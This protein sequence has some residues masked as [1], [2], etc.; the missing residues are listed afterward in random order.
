MI[1]GVVFLGMVALMAWGGGGATVTGLLF[2]VV[3]AAAISLILG[4][5]YRREH[6]P[7]CTAIIVLIAAYF[8]RAW[9]ALERG[10]SFPITA[11]GDAVAWA[12]LAIIVFMAIAVTVAHVVAPRLEFPAA[13]TEYIA[14]AGRPGVGAVGIGLLVLV[15]T[16]AGFRTGMWSHYGDVVKVEAGGVRMELLYFPLLFGFSAAIG[17]MAL[18]ELIG[19]KI[20]LQRAVPIGLMWTLTIVLLFIAQSRRAMLGALILTLVSAWLETSRISLIRTVVVTAGLGVLTIALVVG[21]YL[22]RHAGPATDAVEQLKVISDSSVNIE[23]LSQNLSDRLTYLWIDSASIE[24]YQV[25]QSQFDLLD[26]ANTSVIRATPEL[27][28]PDKYATPKIVCEH[29]YE[30]LGLRTDLPCTPTAEGIIFG[31]VPGLLITAFFFGISLGIVT[32]LY[33]RGTFAS[34]ALGGAAMYHSVL[35]ECSAFPIIDSLRMLVIATFVAGSVAWFLRMIHVIW[36]AKKNDT[37][38]ANI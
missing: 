1:N 2:V 10:F 21:S 6:V 17:R 9:Q 29:A 15:S 30:T 23:D 13:I 18:K 31:G 22:W 27:L 5:V 7:A 26:V 35:I 19:T 12:L 8:P 33:R 24:H 20:D 14:T 28:M 4:F 34:L 38:G 36:T 11:S 3:F 32:A 16:I 25:L 37:G